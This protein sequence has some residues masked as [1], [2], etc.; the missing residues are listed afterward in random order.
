MKSHVASRAIYVTIF[1]FPSK[2]LLFTK[3]NKQNFVKLK[4]KTNN[5]KIYFSIY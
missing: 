2:F 5:N 1:Y 4:P 3:K